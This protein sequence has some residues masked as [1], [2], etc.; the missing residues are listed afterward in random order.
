MPK[1]DLLMLILGVSSKATIP[2]HHSK[3]ALTFV[4]VSSEAITALEQAQMAP[5]SNESPTNS[6]TYGAIEEDSE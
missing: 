6:T 4:R 5:P 1:G 3:D 2:S